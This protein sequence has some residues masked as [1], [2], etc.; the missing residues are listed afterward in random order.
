MAIQT[1]RKAVALLLIFIFIIMLSACGQGTP[2]T[3]AAGYADQ[4]AFL[5]DM[6]KGIKN[7]LAAV[8]DSAH[9]ND[10]DEKK[11]EYYKKLVKY[12]L[13]QIEKYENSVF[14]DNK[15][16]DLV[17]HYIAGC[18][19]QQSACDYMRNPSLYNALWNGGS[20]IRAG[21]ITHL[22]ENY[23]LP[24]SSEEAAYYASNGS[25]SI[26]VSGN[27]AAQS[28]FGNDN[29]VILEKGDLSIQDATGEIVPHSWDNKSD[30]KFQFIIKN[31]SDYDLN[32]IGVKCAILDKDENVL[33]SR[34]ASVNVTVMAGKAA[35]CK[36]QF[37]MEDY[38]TAKYIRVDSINYDGNN[39][40][41][42]HE[43]A[44]D[45]SEIARFTLSIQ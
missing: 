43:I 23:N 9:A 41:I 1:H 17:H 4:Q 11:A 16:N 27:S 42:S 7:R 25:V 19:M 8:D 37:S 24:I 32:Y 35:I 6:A 3:D 38:P 33:D 26:S 22:Y 29:D 10:S 30:Y 40:N 45:E 13:E 28:L 31:N 14:E 5:K 18:K 34:W 2:K 20:T 12:E 15:F 21:I 36:S 44:V 39:N